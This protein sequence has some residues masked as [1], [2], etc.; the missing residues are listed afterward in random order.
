[1]RLPRIECVTRTRTH[2]RVTRW[3]NTCSSK[4]YA[5]KALDGL[6]KRLIGSNKLRKYAN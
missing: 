1:M 5:L 4:I 3:A 2:V 6:D